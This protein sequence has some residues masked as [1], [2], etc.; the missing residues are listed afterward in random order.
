VVPEPVIEKNK[1]AV[2]A[3]F[4]NTWARNGNLLI[5]I[6]SKSFL[7]TIK[8]LKKYL[9]VSFFLLKKLVDLLNLFLNNENMF[10]VEAP[11]GG[12]I[13]RNVIF[14]KSSVWISSLLVLS[15]VPVTQ[16]GTGFKKKL[17]SEPIS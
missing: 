11:K 4:S 7:A 3:S 12:K 9:N 15:P 14:L 8:Y 2:S 1:G 16:V 6:G 10:L 13:N 17:T 5:T